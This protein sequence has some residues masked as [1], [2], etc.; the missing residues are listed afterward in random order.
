M[1]NMNNE[2]DEISSDD[3]NKT[4]VELVSKQDSTT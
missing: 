2:I 4:K 3:S 1:L